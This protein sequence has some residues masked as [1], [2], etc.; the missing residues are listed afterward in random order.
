MH[1]VARFRAGGLPNMREAARRSLSSEVWAYPGFVDRLVVSSGGESRLTGFELHRCK[2]AE[3]R[4]PA[5]CVV[6]AF[7]EV[8]QRSARLIVISEVARSMSS[9]SS[10]AK[11]LSHM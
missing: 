6:E 10:V 11:K 5:V 1:D 7:D 8:D 9:H 3:R 2:I 4:V